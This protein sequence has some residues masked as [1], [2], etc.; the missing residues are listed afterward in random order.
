MQGFHPLICVA[1][2]VTICFGGIVRDLL[3]RRQVGL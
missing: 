2:G 1:G 3:C